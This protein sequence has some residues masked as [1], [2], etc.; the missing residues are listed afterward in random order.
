MSWP[1]PTYTITRGVEVTLPANVRHVFR[2]DRNSP[3]YKHK[4][5]ST[6]RTEMALCQYCK[7]IPYHA[8]PSE[9]EP[10]LPHQPT[11]PALVRS[12][13]TCKLCELLLQ[14][15]Y[16]TRSKIRQE[17]CG[18]NDVPTGWTV[19]E[20]S[21]NGNVIVTELGQ[22]N[23]GTEFFTPG[24]DAS[25][26]GL[27][28]PGCAFVNSEKMKPWLYGSWWTSPGVAASMNAQSL[29]LIGIGLRL[30]TSAELV[31]GEGNSK[32]TSYLRGTPL[33]VR[34][35]P[36]MLSHICLYSGRTDT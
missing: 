12:A 32:E 22:Y 21:A 16:T 20:S 18:G 23:P 28:L 2:A 13:Q 33:R 27:G 24:H 5:P 3:P 11:L 35:L 25:Y 30:G 7:A 10:G 4:D 36:G 6:R 8:L 14:C 1:Q 15:A 34:A 31:D 29:R 17:R 26:R 19:T 9:D